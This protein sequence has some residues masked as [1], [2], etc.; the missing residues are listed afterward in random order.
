VVVNEAMAAGLPLLA[1]VHSQA[2]EELVRDGLEGWLFHPDRPEEM[3]AA[4]DRAFATLPEELARMRQAARDRIRR[5]TPDFVA[6]LFA[7][8]VHDV[9]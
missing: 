5:V 8:V 7:R 9:A 4:L 6:D 1:S 2:V 3:Y